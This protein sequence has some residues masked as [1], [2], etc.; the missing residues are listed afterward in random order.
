[1]VQDLVNLLYGFQQQAETVS[2]VA[3]Y[4]IVVAVVA[5]MACIGDGKGDAG[6]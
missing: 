5:L 6:G 1:M 2:I 4:S 3:Q